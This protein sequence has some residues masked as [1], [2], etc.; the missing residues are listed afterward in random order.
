MLD[1]QLID[2]PTNEPNSAL[3][4]IIKRPHEPFD[5]SVQLQS[6]IGEQDE[7]SIWKEV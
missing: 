3:L 1:Y 7:L 4:P 6:S 5:K 2:A